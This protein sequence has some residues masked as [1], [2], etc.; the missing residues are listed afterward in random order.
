MT[1][2][3]SKRAVLIVAC[4]IA[5]LLARPA[6]GAQLREDTLA[7][8]DR[9]VAATEAQMDEDLRSGHFLLLDRWP[10]SR[11]EDVKEQL[12]SGAL[13]V[14]QIHTLEGGVAIRVPHGL[15]HDWVGMAFIP[16]A[17]LSE[18]MAILR[19]YDNHHNIYKPE[20]R[21]SKLLEHTGNITKVFMQLYSKS[22]VTVVL[23]AD[24]TVVFTQVTPQR[25]ETRSRSTR[26]AELDH[27]GE[28]EEHELPPGNDH[29]FL[30]RL[31]SYWRLEEADGG[32]YVQVE[33]IALSRGIPWELAWLIN[34]LV[35]NISR[36][37]MSR[38]LTET[39]R[40]VTTPKALP[41]SSDASASACPFPAIHDGARAVS[42][43]PSRAAEHP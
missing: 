16:G 32:V 14:R 6:R 15:I 38:L 3:R 42:L 13:Y 40:A 37:Y 9:Y 23:N 22:I 24:F 20:V 7:A 39:R 41:L 30:W 25:A 1:H 18:A 31:D 28:P 43:I 27:P 10:P 5:N 19:D 34:P 11:G 36:S 2:L 8:F 17:K 12:R 33:S 26:I 29:G 21:Q 4:A 35:H